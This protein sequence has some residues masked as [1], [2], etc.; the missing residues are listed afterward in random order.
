M[1][2]RLDDLLTKLKSLEDE[3]ERE[4]E[5]RRA[6]FHYQLSHG[7]VVFEAEA[8]KEHQ[9]LRIGTLRFLRNSPVGTLLIAPFVYG[10]VIPLLVLDLAV[11]LFQAVCFRVWNIAPVRR[12]DYIVLDRYQLG[13][14]NG[15]QKLNCVYCGY[16]NGLVAYVREVA[17][18]TEQ[19][20]CPI[21]HAVRTRNP[22][23]RYRAF[24]EYGD[25]ESYRQR[26]RQLR[27]EVRRSGPAQD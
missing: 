3:F 23:A 17:A 21:K 1:D 14:L 18:R 9:R 16:A 7:R 12:S 5:A 10:V 19:Y 4:V 24:V 13:Y 15:V 6:R 22:H 27:D 2:S 20:W 8:R 26:L 25:A 11:W